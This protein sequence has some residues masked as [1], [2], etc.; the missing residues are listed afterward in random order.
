MQVGLFGVYSG[1]VDEIEE[2]PLGK[3]DVPWPHYIAR[4]KAAG[5]KGF[6]A[7]EFEAEG[8]ERKGV[9]DSAAFMNT[10]MK[11]LA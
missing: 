11:Q 3:G 7:L 2:L 4:L 6:V 5:Y 8:D 1:V 9:S 10:L